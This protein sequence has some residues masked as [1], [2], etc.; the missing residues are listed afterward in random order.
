MGWSRKTIPLGLAVGLGTQVATDHMNGNGTPGVL[1][2][3]R[4]GIDIFSRRP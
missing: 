2:A 1:V 4:Y 3:A